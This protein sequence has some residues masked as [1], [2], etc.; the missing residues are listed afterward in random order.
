MSPTYKHDVFISF[1]FKDR[2]LAEEIVN[3]LFSL[4]GITSWICTG[5]IYGGSRYKK[6]IVDAIEQAQV[7]VFLQ[8]SSSVI[9]KEVP[10]EI[11]IAFDAGK[12]IIPFKL[13]DAKLLSKDLQYDL[14]GVEFIDATVP[15]F[16]ERIR[17]LALA[18]KRFLVVSPNSTPVSISTGNCKKL[19]STPNVVPKS[20]FCGR[21][22]ILQQIHT[23]FSNGERVLF[24]H[25]IGGIGKTQIAMQY[26]KRHRSDYDVVVFATYSGSIRDL[27]IAEFP[28]TLEPPLIRYT[29]SDGTQEDDHSFFMRK[30]EH[31]DKI[32]AQEKVLIII[33]NMDSEEDED[34]PALMEGN[35]HLL[36]TSRCD[37][38]RYYPTITVS[39]IDSM[40]TL[41]DIFMRN[42]RGDEV[43]ADDPD[44]MA[45]IELVNRHT[46]TI[47][48]L[49][50]HM[51]NSGQTA[52]EMSQALK[53][54]GIVS[55]NETIQSADMKKHIAY[56]NLRKMFKIFSLNEEERTVLMYLSL[57][58]AEGVAV[59][60][61][62]KWAGL[63]SS[64][65]LNN[66]E[67]R[68]W[69]TRTPEGIALH[70]VIKQVIQYEIPANSENCFDFINKF[71]DDITESVIWHWKK[72]TKVKYGNIAANILSVC[73]ELSPKTEMLADRA[74]RLM[75]F[76]VDVGLA[77]DLAKRLYQY[78]SDVYG[79]NSH[80]AGTAAFRLGWIYQTYPYIHNAQSLAFE[81]LNK[82]MSILAKAESS[83]IEELA[84]LTM[85]KRTLSSLYLNMYKENRDPEYYRLAKE[86]AESELAQVSKCF[87]E[88]GKHYARIAGAHANLSA[89]L[90]SKEET[91]DLE[92]AL[93]H[94]EQALERLVKL[95]T[96]NDLDSYFALHR[97]AAVLFAMKRFGEAKA[98]AKESAEGYYDYS[99]SD[100]PLIIDMFVLWGDC[101]DVLDEHNEARQV[102]EKALAITEALYIPGAKQIVAI[103]DKLA[104]LRG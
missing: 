29:L 102:Y 64:R 19:L 91:P 67:T 89:V 88:G 37:F 28:F 52:G 80:K 50:Q 82:A 62:K 42:Y 95:Y 86:Y 71:A 24:L 68:S 22:D 31:I 21:E 56:E 26:I 66:L 14:A 40:E 15:T 72:S 54:H 100:R 30:I 1:S 92:A 38:S 49:A 11:G 10:K 65:T 58:P 3:K 104:R 20:I 81:W 46:Y 6:D 77:E 101:C 4:Y 5:N 74:Q 70:P 59:R 57:M 13:D 99:G 69:I 94:A 73:N 55:L 44:L 90:L 36:I 48:L 75:S 96:Q 47:E 84:T 87:H 43:T 39:P 7:L 103:Q 53:A 33:D 17:D 63:T 41:K 98:A 93:D 8:S 25:G 18:I 85:L 79:P 45:L 9:S 78:Y 23:N 83:T 35:S 12:P 16:D 51:E 60:D 61:F 34:L 32:A 97:K 27:V 2:I 76:W